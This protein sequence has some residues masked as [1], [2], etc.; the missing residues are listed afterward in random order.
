MVFCLSSFKY[1]NNCKVIAPDTKDTAY[2][3][4]SG[5]H[6]V[7]N[8]PY[9][10]KPNGSVDIII[11]NPTCKILSDYN[12]LNHDNNLSISIVGY[13][14]STAEEFCI[15]NNIEFKNIKYY[16]SDYNMGI[17]DGDIIEYNGIYFKYNERNTYLS[18]TDIKIIIV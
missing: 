1:S 16:N 2:L 14:D 17:N 8:K 12:F 6:D 4:S 18:L 7:D 15:R 11:E 5:K 13:P 10:Y 9:V 3:S